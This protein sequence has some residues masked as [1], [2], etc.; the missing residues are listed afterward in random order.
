MHTVPTLNKYPAKREIIVFMNLL[1]EITKQ[2]DTKKYKTIRTF[3]FLPSG[4]P[5]QWR[6]NVELLQEE[7]AELQRQNAELKDRITLQGRELIRTTHRFT[8]KV[9]K[10]IMLSWLSSFF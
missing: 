8:G 4:S 2:Q 6:V 5:T 1:I 9:I 7:N 3:N 10:I